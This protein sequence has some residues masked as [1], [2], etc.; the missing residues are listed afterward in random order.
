MLLLESC[1]SYYLYY[2]SIFVD[3]K[4]LDCQF[5]KTLQPNPCWAGLDRELTLLRS[6][7]IYIMLAV[8]VSKVIETLS[9]VIGIE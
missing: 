4:Y 8:P 5:R 7:F 3:G 1:V 9:L 6:T 2:D